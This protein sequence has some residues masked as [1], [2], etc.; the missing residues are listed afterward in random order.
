[1]PDRELILARIEQKQQQIRDLQEAIDFHLAHQERDGSFQ[2]RGLETEVADLRSEI[3]S[4]Y[5]QL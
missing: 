5:D 4:L 3:S 1:M 2:G